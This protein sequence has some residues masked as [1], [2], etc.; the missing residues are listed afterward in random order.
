MLGR[1]VWDSLKGLFLA[2]KEILE[3]RCCFP[4]R[5]YGGEECLS[6]V[7]EMTVG[8]LSLYLYGVYDLYGACRQCGKVERVLN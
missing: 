7:M 8:F 3:R 6:L 1:C 5:Y 2:Q 4:N